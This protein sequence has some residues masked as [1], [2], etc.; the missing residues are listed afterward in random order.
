MI[1]YAKTNKTKSGGDNTSLG[2]PTSPEQ[3]FLAKVSQD[4]FR[5][6]PYDGKYIVDGSRLIICQSNAR[7]EDIQCAFKR[8]D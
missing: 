5:Y 3:R 8:R 2:M 7:K 6:H 1:T 4:I